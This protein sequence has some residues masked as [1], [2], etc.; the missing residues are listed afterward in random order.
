[1]TAA[2]DKNNFNPT[3]RRVLKNGV[4]SPAL[5]VTVRSRRE[6][7]AYF[8]GFLGLPYPKSIVDRIANSEHKQ[9]AGAAHAFGEVAGQV[10]A[11]ELRLKVALVRAN[12]MDWAALPASI[13]TR[14]SIMAKRYE[15]I[16]QARQKKAAVPLV[17][18]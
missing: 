16:L 7:A 6:Y 10:I 14:A 13:Q 3:L 17:P 8:G 15:L 18:K 12:R 5:D 4:A 11:Q 1:M 2:P 9:E